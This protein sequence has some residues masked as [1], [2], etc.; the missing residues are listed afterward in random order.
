M[1]AM[2][3]L[4]VGYTYAPP[5]VMID[6]DDKPYG[7]NV[8]L[9]EQSADDLDLYY[10]YIEMPFGEM[11][12]ALSEGRIDV[13]IN[14]LTISSE[15]AQNIDFTLP[16]F[17]TS[18]VVAVTTKGG[19]HRILDFIKSI[20]NLNFLRVVAGL[21][22]LIGTFGLIVWF[23]ERHKNPVHFR[24]GWKGIWDGLW[25]SAVTM[26]TVGYGDKAPKSRG[27]KLIALVW[28]FSGIIFISGFTASIASSLTI[29]HIHVSADELMDFKDNK[30]GCINGTSTVGY[31]E[32]YFFKNVTTYSSVNEGLDAL[33]NH[34][35]KAFLYDEPILKY[36]LNEQPQYQPIVMLPIKFNSQFYAFGFNQ[37]KDALRERFNPIMLEHLESF[38]WRIILSEYDL[39]E[40]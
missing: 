38:D 40:F 23:F 26:T 15:R 22:F 12:T 31:L 10:S 34:H 20:F 13:S 8:W 30:V 25:W 36:K 21:V 16:Y 27:G 5:F 29:N 35:I 9:W 17:S 4:L 37:K 7:I 24:P 33:L 19:W 18:S 14:P 2:D 28:M 11:M 6:Q 32:R 39:E 1:D 3:T